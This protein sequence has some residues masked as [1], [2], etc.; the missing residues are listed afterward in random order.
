APES[1]ECTLTPWPDVHTL[2]PV[3]AVHTLAPEPELHALAPCAA[4]VEPPPVAGLARTSEARAGLATTVAPE[5]VTVTAPG[6]TCWQPCLWS[7]GG[8]A[9]ASGAPA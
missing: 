4:T 8:K 6:F 1:D 5:R 3:P 2:A 9:K 7:Q